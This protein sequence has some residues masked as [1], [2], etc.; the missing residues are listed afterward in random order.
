MRKSRASLE[1]FWDLKI[2]KYV[3]YLTPV[4]SE[5]LIS[6]ELLSLISTAG[7]T[8]RA[9]LAYVIPW[10]PYAIYSTHSSMP[11]LT[12]LKFR[13]CTALSIWLKHQNLSLSRSRVGLRLHLCGWGAGMR[14][15]TVY[16][17]YWRPFTICTITAMQLLGTWSRVSL[18]Y[19]TLHYPICPSFKVNPWCIIFLIFANF[20]YL[21]FF[22]PVVQGVT[23]RF[24]TTPEEVLAVLEEGKSGRHVSVTS[25]SAN[26][27]KS[28]ESILL[29]CMGSTMLIP[30]P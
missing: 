12:D 1:P 19:I 29:E 10:R 25:E 27:C 24:V 22:L 17:L 8:S 6:C 28:R 9:F 26:Y 30:P 20:S 4:S 2:G 11:R 3:E 15:C 23:E 7:R 14:H 5:Y 21:Y 16:A 18:P 13:S